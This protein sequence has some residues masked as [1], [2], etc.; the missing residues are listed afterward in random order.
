MYLT[1]CLPALSLGSSTNRP[2]D[3][4]TEPSSSAGSVR[5]SV[6]Q[7]GAWQL[8]DEIILIF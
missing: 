6:V 2:V 1:K 7:S 5:P 4:V 3:V 8:P